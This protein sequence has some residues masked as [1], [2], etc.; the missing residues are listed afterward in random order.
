[1]QYQKMEPEAIEADALNVS[2][3]LFMK[4]ASD[5]HPCS[6]VTPVYCSPK[7]V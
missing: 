6:L 3:A 1:M 7:R 2:C 5:I 4:Y